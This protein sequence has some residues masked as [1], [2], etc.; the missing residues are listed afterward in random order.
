MKHL[1]SLL[2]GLSYSIVTIFTMA[3][4]FYMIEN[5]SQGHVPGFEL[6]TISTIF[7]GFMLSSSIFSNAASDLK[8]RMRRVGAI[9]LVAA[10]AFVIFHIFFSI[11]DIM[12]QATNIH[13]ISL[14]ENTTLTLPLIN[15]NVN[16]QEVTGWI[17]ISFMYIGIIGLALALWSMI[18]FVIPRLLKKSNSSIV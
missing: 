16:P 13:S 10:V 11:L 14:T 3:L 9:Y 18:F 5:F 8:L 15:F 17:A 12:P 7:G 6:A 2:F 4:A 1:W